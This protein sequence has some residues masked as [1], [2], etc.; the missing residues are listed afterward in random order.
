MR[1][2]R[3]AAL[4]AITV[5]A[6]AAYSLRP[7]ATVGASPASTH[8]D[9]AV[10]KNAAKM[11]DQGRHTFRYD[12]F[13]D[14]D[15]WG[16]TLHLHQ[17]LEGSQF[18]GVGPGVSPAT[19]LAVGLKVDVDALPP[20]LIAALRS[21]QVNLSSPETTLA[22]LK[23]N[24]VLGVTGYF[25]P[26]GTL[27]SVGIQCALCH[28]TV[29]R[30]FS[31]PGI[32]PG[33]IGHR[34]DGWANRDLNVGAIVSL[35]PNLE[36]VADVLQVDVPTVKTVLASWG[37]GKFD[38]ELFMDGKAFRPDGKSAATLIPPAFG[39]AGVNLHT[40]TGWGSVPYWNAFVAN[41]EMHGKGTFFDP[42]LDDAAQFPV[43]ARNHFG[44]VNSQ[45]DLITGKLPALHFYQLSIPAPAPPKGSFDEAAAK[46]GDELFSGKAQCTTCHTE[47]LWTEPGWDLHTGSEICIDSFQ[48]DRAPDH[49]YRTAPLNGLWT[50][51]KG[52][53]YHDGRFATLLDVVNHYDSCFSL[54]L[55]AQE[56]SDLVE[57]LKSLPA[58]Q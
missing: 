20:S 49:R 14:Q 21:G 48:A 39:L 32:P 33:N 42:R 30:S 58:E 1:P 15:F 45:P 34:L 52:G 38:A 8:F 5:A 11:L 27:R 7:R 37:P 40:W 46:R 16:G 29:D 25:N 55:S 53:F 22:L 26:N 47:P 18:G 23:Q 50:H 36:P 35:A 6:V 3:T 43:A 9:V 24:A 44:H 57:Y 28:S 19:A 2:F 13:G 10:V 12:T 17:A 41:L 51:T 56:K 4:L 54:G 31:A